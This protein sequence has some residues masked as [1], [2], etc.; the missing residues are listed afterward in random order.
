MNM[1]DSKSISGA[2]GATGSTFTTI[3]S[4]GVNNT[5]YYAPLT[6]NPPNI[7]FNGSATPASTITQVTSPLVIHYNGTVIDVG[8]AI[9]M[10]TE[11]LLV[12][13]PNF[14]KHEKYQALK[15]AYDHYKLIESMIKDEH[16]SR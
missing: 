3:T 9:T 2:V 1:I 14:E 11:R 7:V 4:S 16:N 15:N 8:Q 12:L 10:L 6:A 5:V 13:A